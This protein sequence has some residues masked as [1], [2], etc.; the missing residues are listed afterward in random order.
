MIM[1]MAMMLMMSIL[2]MSRKCACN[3]AMMPDVFKGNKCLKATNHSSPVANI[4]K[5]FFLVLYIKDI[6]HLHAIL[7]VCL[8]VGVQ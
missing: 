5:G 2:M 1:L 7:I 4:L 3:D 6:H 8:G